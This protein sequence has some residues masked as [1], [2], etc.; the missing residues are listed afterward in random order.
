MDSIFKITKKGQCGITIDGL[1]KDAGEY[2]SETVTTVSTRLYKYSQTI[3]LNTLTVVK[4]D[5]VETLNQNKV[6][7]HTDFP[8]DTDYF[9]LPT[10]GLFKVTHIILPTKVW[11]DYVI[12]NDKPAL[13]IYTLIYYYDNG[14]FYKYSEEE[15]K[16]VTIEEILMVNP[17]PPIK[18]TDKTTTII[19][20][21]KNT[22]NLYN[23]ESCF[24][25]LNKSLLSSLIGGCV[26]NLQDNSQSVF[27]RDL[28]W[29]SI[30][31]IKYLLGLQQ[32]YEAQRILDQIT[33]CGG[34]CQPASST[35]KINPCGCTN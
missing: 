1:E 32:L 30:N 27:N 28:I 6:L 7:V 22:F 14:L 10:D 5:G 13:D 23:L 12:A 19:R 35:V 17:A 33:G 16:E 9:D 2:M 15:I 11:L 34:L 4:A 24:Y 18:P 26:K 8:V 29:M 3:T 21:D 25:T 20:S 31:V